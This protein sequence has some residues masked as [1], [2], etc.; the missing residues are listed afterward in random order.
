MKMHK[1]NQQPRIPFDLEKIKVPINVDLCTGSNNAHIICLGNDHLQARSHLTDH[2]LK[3]SDI[4]ALC[5][6]W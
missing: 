2:L 5:I 6:T 1:F 3:F 4:R